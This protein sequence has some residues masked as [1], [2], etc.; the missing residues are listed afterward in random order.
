MP[1]T[2]VVPASECEHDRGPHGSGAWK[3]PDKHSGDDGRRGEQ[4]HP[5]GLYRPIVREAPERRRVVRVVGVE[6]REGEEGRTR[7]VERD[8]ANRASER[9]GERSEPGAEKHHQNRDE[10]ERVGLGIAANDEHELEQTCTE[11][12]GR[13]DPPEHARHPAVA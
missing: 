3:P 12:E 7:R 2:A 6:A 1:I 8:R 4:E 10:R 5:G 9:D 13:H 11:Q